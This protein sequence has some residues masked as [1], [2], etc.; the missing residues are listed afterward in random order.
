MKNYAV[1]FH[2][3]ANS[4]H[5]CSSIPFFV[6]AHHARAHTHLHTA[7]HDLF[8]MTS[9]NKCHNQDNQETVIM[10]KYRHKTLSTQLF[11]A[12]CFTCFI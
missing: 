7:G 5:M 2:N 11:S 10:T 1:F 3:H 9:F 12:T 4:L 8:F 6:C